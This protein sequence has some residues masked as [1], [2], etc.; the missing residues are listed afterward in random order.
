MNVVQILFPRALDQSFTYKIPDNQP[1]L[2]LGQFV[3][4]SF[5]REILIG[6][7]WSLKPPATLPP[8]LK[9]YTRIFDIPP[10]S[11]KTRNFIEWVASYYMAPL[12][13]VLKMAMSVDTAIS[14]SPTQKILNFVENPP[15]FKMTAARQ[16]LL[17]FMREK[18]AVP[19]TDIISDEISS[20]AVIKGLVDHGALT[21]SEK[22]LN[23]FG[24]TN[25]SYNAVP[26]TAAQE[27]AY[28]HIQKD[29]D[30][31]TF[32]VSLL[33]GVTGSGKTEVYFEA[34]SHALNQGKQSLVL[35][36]EIALTTQWLSRFERRFGTPPVLWHSSLS[37]KVRKENWRKILAGNAG[38]VVGARSALMLPFPELGLVI[39]DE[40]HEASYKQEEGVRYHAR[41][42]AI[43]RA[44]FENCPLVLASATPS[45]E[46]LQNVEQGRYSLLTLPERH[47]GATMPEVKLIDMAKAQKSGKG[48][49][50]D[51]LHQAITETLARKEQVLLFLNRRGYA[52]LTLCKQCGFRHQCVQCS[53]WLVYHQK[54]NMLVCHHC[55][56]GQPHELKCPSCE[57][58][59]GM[60]TFGPGVERIEEEARKAF[61]HARI[62]IMSSDHQ[63]SWK[64]TQALISSIENRDLDILIG[65]QMA[66]KGHHFKYLTLVGVI[67]GDSGISGPDPRAAERC[68][69]L[70]HQVSGRAG[71]EQLQGRVYIQT[72]SP[73]HPLMQ[74]LHSGK[75]DDFIE[76]ETENREEW[77][78]PPFGRL[79]S[80]IVTSKDLSEATQTASHLAQTA[81]L[82]EGVSV[83]GPAQAPLFFLQGNYRFRL[84]LKMS[85]QQSLQKYLNSWLEGTKTKGRVSI[86][87]DVDPQ[88]FM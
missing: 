84:L 32:H 7:I 9:S 87:I 45:L 46:S 43:M 37:D 62:G 56:Y 70:L 36:P 3:Q 85:K 69:Q 41:D 88:N 19:Y 28:Q 63:K 40:E 60:I 8:K 15:T 13:N 67:D 6:V 78:L 11:E 71:R 79:A 76:I 21:I 58:D 74:A 24:P 66:T 49:I 80:L 53:S 4:A 14:L 61:P 59:D 10:L 64:D 39:V 72:F 54:K 17:D 86:D 23:L 38:V 73:N 2:K 57:A 30:K 52:P 26:L 82:V 83:L 75:R 5:G 25:F 42:A 81:P 20:N 16:K 55:G 34:I 1:P 31:D 29:I 68:Y 77:H 47:G 27:T 33:D 50:S 51:V 22:K 18:K 44:K 48:F 35:M 12:G 65:T